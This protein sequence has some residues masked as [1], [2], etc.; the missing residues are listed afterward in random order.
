MKKI[1]SI[2][3]AAIISTSCFAQYV[4]PCVYSSC[5]DIYFEKETERGREAVERVFRDLN[6]GLYRGI[7]Q[8][9]YDWDLKQGS[10]LIFIKNFL[11]SYLRFKIFM[12]MI[13]KEN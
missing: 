5:D 1:I 12:W 4:D 3:T 13:L 7:P 2:L 11:F 8:S 10:F 6:S 9:F